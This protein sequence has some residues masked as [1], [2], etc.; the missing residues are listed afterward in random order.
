MDGDAA[1]V[2][3]LLPD[4]LVIES[5][6]TR[7]VTRVEQLHLL[8]GRGVELTAVVRR[9]RLRDQRLEEIDELSMLV[10]GCDVLI[11][12]LSDGVLDSPYWRKEL[13]AAVHAGVAVELVLKE[14]ARWPDKYN[15][16]TELFPPPRLIERAFGA[17]PDE[18]PI[19][20]VFHQKAIQHSLEP[21]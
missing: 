1:Q 19:R 7:D 15:Q 17:G 6:L 11:C 10:A 3:D 4:E 21:Q 12:V 9:W 13:A 16:L 8:K 5:L 2:L 20:E 14:G 18:A